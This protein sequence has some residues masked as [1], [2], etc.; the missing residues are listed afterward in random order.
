MTDCSY[1]MKE[2]YEQCKINPVLCLRL[3]KAYIL[4][5]VC[6]TGLCPALE[7]ILLLFL[8]L[9]LSYSFTVQIK[10]ALAHPL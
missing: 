9:L 2:M 5:G 10:D 6:M 8:L 1:C 7:P 4:H 3:R